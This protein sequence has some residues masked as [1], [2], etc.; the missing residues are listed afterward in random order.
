MRIL[1]MLLMA[2]VFVSPV[3]A[4]WHKVRSPNF[5]IYS[6]GKAEQTIEFARKLERFDTFLRSRFKLPNTP[7]PYPLTIFLTGSSM[8][9]AKLYGKGRRQVLGFYT[10]GPDGPVAISDRVQGGG[11]RLDLDSETVLMHEYVHHFMFQYSPAAYPAWFVE[12]FAEFYS[13]TDFDGEGRAQFGKPALHRAYDLVI[14]D[15]IPART[16]LTA[17]TRSLNEEQTRSFY[18]RSWLTT[19]YLTFDP[20][21]QGQLAKYMAELGSGTQ[22]AQAATMAFGDLE[23]FDRDLNAYRDRRRMSF[24]TETNPTV[25]PAD[26]RTVG[27]VPGEAAIITERIR[28]MR[29]L[30]DEERPAVIA[31]LSKARRKLPQSAVIPALMAQVHY[32]GDNDADAIAAA[33]AALALDASEPRATFYKALAE[34][35]QLVRAEVTSPERWKATRALIV[36]ANR[37]NPDNPYPLFHYFRSFQQQGIEPTPLAVTGLARAQQIVPQDEE[38]RYHY[39]YFL[40]GE[41]RYREALN[42]IKPVAFDPHA[43]SDTGPKLVAR[44]ER[45]IAGN[46]DFEEDE[47]PDLID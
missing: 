2:L 22:P 6:E 38:I 25:A 4:E 14:T 23:K 1:A 10:V 13:T 24:A 7:A 18:A 37:A 21:R 41:K 17:E 12:G 34:M 20:A 27:L 44:L 33:D 39:A 26:I 29:G 40:I 8:P 32:G 36:K 35:R 30:H 28:I 11:G 45:A 19:H 15:A 5:I 43:D 47:A 16:L 46:S 42:L 9:A 3:Q 31:S